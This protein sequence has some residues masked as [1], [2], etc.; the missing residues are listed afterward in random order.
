MHAISFF[1]EIH[2]LKER[3]EERKLKANAEKMV[4]SMKQFLSFELFLQRA[5]NV[6]S[7]VLRLRGEISRLKILN[8]SLTLGTP[9]HKLDFLLRKT[10]MDMGDGASRSLSRSEEDSSSSLSNIAYVPPGLEGGLKAIEVM[11]MLAD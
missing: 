2:M 6:K 9:L 3:L 4:K 7:E 10:S 8:T 1:Y 11:Q 5:Q